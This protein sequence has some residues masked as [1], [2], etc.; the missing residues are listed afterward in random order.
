MYGFLGGR[1]VEG[2]ESRCYIDG[3]GSEG[4]GFGVMERFAF[5]CLGLFVFIMIERA[6]V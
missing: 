2:L 4:T 6:V 1:L 3:K 5:C